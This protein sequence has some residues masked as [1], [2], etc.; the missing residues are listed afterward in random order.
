MWLSLGGHKALM[1]DCVLS[2]MKV[3]I[4]LLSPNFCASLVSFCTQPVW[5]GNPLFFDVLAV[6]STVM[7]EYKQ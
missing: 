7:V 6:P 1:S 3:V 2:D 4:P 5:A